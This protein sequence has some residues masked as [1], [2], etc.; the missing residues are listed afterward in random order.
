MKFE[1]R[2]SSMYEILDVSVGDERYF[3]ISD[4]DFSNRSNIISVIFSVGVSEF[5]SCDVRT[6]SLDNKVFN[7]FIFFFIFDNQE[8]IDKNSNVVISEFRGLFGGKFNSDGIFWRFFFFL[9]VFVSIFNFEK[10]VSEKFKVVKKEKFLEKIEGSRKFFDILNFK[11]NVNQC[12]FQSNFMRQ[13]F[14]SFRFEQKEMV[15]GG[16]NNL[17]GSGSGGGGE[18]GKK[19]RIFVDY[20]KLKFMSSL[21][22]SFSQG[23]EKFKKK[24]IVDVQLKEQFKM[25]LLSVKLGVIGKGNFIDEIFFVDDS[26]EELV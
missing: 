17:S 8:L 20:V 5:F 12:E 1:G 22:D 26:D 25:E 24:I 15:V 16:D 23:E 4:Y 19:I 2:K 18:V 3:L 6:S 21:E 11:S 7:V 10:S 13:Y 14:G 9:L